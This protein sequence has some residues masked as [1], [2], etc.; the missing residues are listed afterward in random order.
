[1]ETPE[2]V[3]VV[4]V[5]VA[6]AAAAAVTVV[7]VGAAA[8]GTGNQLQAVAGT[9]QENDRQL[10]SRHQCRPRADSRWS[11]RCR[12]DPVRSP[13]H[14]TLLRPFARRPP[15]SLK[16]GDTDAQA[17]SS[18]LAGNASRA[19]AS[20]LYQI[21]QRA[22]LVAVDTRAAGMAVPP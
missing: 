16:V 12:F 5:V 8:T 9:S 10:L 15:Q 14:L 4:V 3:V 17:Q 6:A 1:M 13:V 19:A 2:T 20:L 11:S 18:V 7:A 22:L 21:P